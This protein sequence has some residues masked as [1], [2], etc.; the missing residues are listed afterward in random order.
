MKHT[1]K[2][3]FHFQ[4]IN[5]DNHDAIYSIINDKPNKRLYIL[6][7]IIPVAETYT[8]I[9]DLNNFIYNDDNSTFKLDMNHNINII[10][11]QVTQVDT[12]TFNINLY[13]YDIDDNK[14]YSFTDYC[15]WIEMKGIKLT[16][17]PANLYREVKIKKLI[18]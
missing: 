5:N 15:V 4:Y 6:L 8:N 7:E 2:K 17:E 18:E 3:Y 1:K 11:L 12:T 9:I 10:T 16:G 14:Y 13:L